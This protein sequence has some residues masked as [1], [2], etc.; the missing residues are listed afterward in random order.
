[1]VYDHLSDFDY[2]L[3]KH[4]IAHYPLVERSASRLLRLSGGNL[5][6]SHGCFSD[7]L[8]HLQPNDLLV[9]NNTKVFPARLYGRKAS[10]GKVECLIERVLSD[11][12]ALV[13]LKSSKSPKPGSQIIFS[14]GLTAELISRAGDLFMLAFD[15]SESL[16]DVLEKIGEVPLPPYIDR[17][18]ERSDK[19]RY[20]TVYAACPGAVAAPTAGLH[21]TPE[22]LASLQQKNINIAAITLHVG[23]GTFQTIRV[24]NLNEHKMHS[25]MIEV[26]DATCIAIQKCRA[27]GGRVIAVGT[28]S[29]RALESASKH[30]KI[31]PYQG[32]T[33]L[34][35]RPGYNFQCVDTLITNFHL[36][37]SSLLVLVSAFGGYDLIMQA[38]QQAIEKEYRFFSYGDAMM[39]DRVM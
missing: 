31:T 4:L 9:V 22:L 28:T 2:V 20:Q 38:Y 5:D 17:S 23:A 13:H 24:S 37:Q 30:G 8:Q 6:I 10:G 11:N 19:D 35:I 16:Y 26:S 15:C 34:F 32:E 29:L 25:E 12:R 18:V 21:F 3:P 33:D 7:V 36:P 39:I 27:A 14:T 1:M